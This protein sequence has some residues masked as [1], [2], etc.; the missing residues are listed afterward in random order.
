MK[1]EDASRIASSLD[2]IATGLDKLNELLQ[3]KTQAAKARIPKWT[4]VIGT[5]VAVVLIWS[6]VKTGHH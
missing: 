1:D 5:I 3:R 6:M 4:L 2:R